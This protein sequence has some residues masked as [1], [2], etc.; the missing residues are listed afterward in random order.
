M[1]KHKGVEDVDQRYKLRRVHRTAERQSAL[2][3]VSVCQTGTTHLDRFGGAKGGGGVAMPLSVHPLSC[4]SSFQGRPLFCQ[5]LSLPGHCLIRQPSSVT[6]CFMWP[7]QVCTQSLHFLFAF[8]S[9]V[10]ASSGNQQRHC[11]LHGPDRYADGLGLSL[12][13]LPEGATVALCRM[14]ESRQHTPVCHASRACRQHS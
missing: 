13:A 10:I 1:L 8:A 2:L 9:L 5:L 3:A 14:A 4:Q 11:L 12:F 7:N 6:I